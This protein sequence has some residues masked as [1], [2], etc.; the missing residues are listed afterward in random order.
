VS[1]N[2]K[3]TLSQACVSDLSALAILPSWS[4]PGIR[5]SLFDQPAT[6]GK[7]LDHVH[8]VRGFFVS[9]RFAN[10]QSGQWCSSSGDGLVN[11]VTKFLACP[12]SRS[13]NIPPTKYRLI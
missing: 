9:K 3:S 7:F 8:D 5:A 4:L 2:Q 1:T 12:V 6:C 13:H 11:R 10:L